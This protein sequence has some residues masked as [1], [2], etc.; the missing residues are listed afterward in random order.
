MHS[1]SPRFDAQAG[2]SLAQHPYAD[3]PHN[4][5]RTAQDCLSL[6]HKSGIVMIMYGPAPQSPLKVCAECEIPSDPHPSY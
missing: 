1:L 3:K 4:N 5:T 6:P 2:Y